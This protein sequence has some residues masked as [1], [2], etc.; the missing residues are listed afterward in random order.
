MS[1][2]SSGPAGALSSSAAADVSARHETPVLLL[3][4]GRLTFHLPAS[5]DVLADG[6]VA[7]RGGGGRRLLSAALCRGGAGGGGGECRGE[8]GRLEPV[9]VMLT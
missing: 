9:L 2:F 1:V 3:L 8:A 5:T 7:G 6:E 4:T